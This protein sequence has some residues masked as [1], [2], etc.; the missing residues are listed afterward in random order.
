M[1]T[2]TGCDWT[3]STGDSWITITS[4][5]SGTGSGT[6]GYTVAA[7]PGA[8]RT[9][10][11]TIGDQILVVIQD[12]VGGSCAFSIS[13]TGQLFGGAGGT[14]SIKLT[15]QVGCDWTA[16]TTETW[17]N[18]N[19]GSSGTGS[20]TVNYTIAAHVG[21]PRSGTIT[22]AGLTFTV[23]QEEG[24]CI[25]SLSPTVANFPQPGGTGSLTVSTP[26]PCNWTAVPTVPWLLVQGGPSG[27]GN[28]TVLYFVASNNTTEQR[29]GTL[30][31]AG[32]EF[33]VIQE[34]VTPLTILTS[35][36]PFGV[37]GAQY[38]HQIVAAGG[39]PP[40][41]WSVVAGSLPPGMSLDSA[42]LLSGSPTVADEFTFTVRV[43]D[44]GSQSAQRQL[45][46]TIFAPALTMTQT[47]LPGA[48]RGVQYVRQL[49]ATGGH[50]PYSWAITGG[51]LPPGINLDP[52]TGVLSGAATAS[53]TFLFTVTVSDQNSATASNLLRLLVVEPGATPQITKLK[54]RNHFKLV[55]IGRNF[56]ATSRVLVDG[57][58][59]VPIFGDSTRLVVKRLV[60]A[61]GV[62]EIR[63]VNSNGISSSAASLTVD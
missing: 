18:I 1:T 24:F 48:V 2:E 36:L 46:L 61:A 17:I 47:V 33:T 56:E 9:G 51:A 60:L 63:V 53:G 39:T 34:G 7:N 4:G 44:L 52:N 37:R 10:S 49:T 30:L 31:I 15:T 62:H 45:S 6:V 25:G 16:S 43:R 3:A 35:S 20:G 50:P 38:N 14:G 12:A 29:V 55:V 19:S 13:P 59:L 41:V 11:I 22:V 32:Q 42:G 58:S 54:Y 23:S 40:Y 28:A 57:Q 5:S 27:F 8:A 21:P 26:V